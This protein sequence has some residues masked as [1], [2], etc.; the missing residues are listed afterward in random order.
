MKNNPYKYYD[1]ADTRKMQVVFL[2]NVI[3]LTK[4]KIAEITKLAVSTVKNYCSKFKNLLEQAKKFF[5][6]VSADNKRHRKTN[7]D[8][9][10]KWE[11]LPIEKPCGYCLEFYSGNQF[12][13]LKVGMTARPV[14]ERIKEHFGYY[15][16]KGFENLRCVVKEL[17][18]VNTPEMAEVTESALREVYKRNHADAFL[19]KDRFLDVKY[20]AE[21]KE[22]ARF[23]NFLSLA[24]AA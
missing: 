16:E 5:S 23:L 8:D 24:Q 6:A 17:Y 3:K 22:D 1:N 13:W 7:L 21:E 19:P 10:I 11:V 15:A 9:R 20:T 4:E 18:E 12:L 14:R 2:Y